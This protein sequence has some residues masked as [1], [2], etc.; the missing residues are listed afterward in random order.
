MQKKMNLVV[1]MSKPYVILIY[2]DSFYIYQKQV[3]YHTL[4]DFLA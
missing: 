3:A 2:G 4:H 1:L